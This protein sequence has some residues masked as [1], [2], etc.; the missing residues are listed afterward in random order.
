MHLVNQFVIGIS[1]FSL[2]LFRVFLQATNIILNRYLSFFFRS[3]FS[4][5]NRYITSE[6]KITLVWMPFSRMAYNEYKEGQYISIC[7]NDLCFCFHKICKMVLQTGTNCPPMFSIFRTF[8]LKS[9]YTVYYEQLI[10][11]KLIIYFQ[12]VLM[13]VK[14]VLVLKEKQRWMGKG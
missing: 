11:A 5:L 7:E 14:Y 6:L 12:R 4:N 8:T 3:S 10:F 2:F 13:V 1:F 9:K